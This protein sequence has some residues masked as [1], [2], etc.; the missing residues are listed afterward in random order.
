MRK[1][2]TCYVHPQWFSLKIKQT[3]C[4]CLAT[5]HPAVQTSSLGFIQRHPPLYVFLCLK[6]IHTHTLSCLVGR[7]E[8]S[9]I[10]HPL[11]QLQQ[12]ALKGDMQTARTHADMMRYL[13][14]IMA[15]N[16]LLAKNTYTEKR[17]AGKYLDYDIK[18][19]LATLNYLT[20]P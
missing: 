6:E 2:Q 14:L 16:K 1:G 11:K 10:I 18:L 12:P 20:P 17:K 19:K 15:V 7:R 3:H 9:C 4:Y 8:R 5:T 13:W